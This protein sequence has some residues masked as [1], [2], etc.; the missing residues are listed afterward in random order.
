[1]SPLCS[2]PYRHNALAR[3]VFRLGAM[4]LVCGPEKRNTAPTTTLVAAG[5]SFQTPRMH[6]D[7]NIKEQPQSAAA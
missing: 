6:E 4:E 5:D 2:V 7:Q 1:M 3:C